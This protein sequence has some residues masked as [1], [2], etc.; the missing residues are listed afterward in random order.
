MKDNYLDQPNSPT[1]QTKEPIK[2]AF[3]L[4]FDNGYE[5][6]D[7]E[8]SIDNYDDICEKLLE[9]MKSDYLFDECKIERV[10]TNYEIE[11][12]TYFTLNSVEYRKKVIRYFE[13]YQS[14]LEKTSDEIVEMNNIIKYLTFKID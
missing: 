8:E 12:E 9:I 13:L 14:P 4:N 10:S 5:I 11:P 6:F 1:R 3:Q 2:Y 7:F